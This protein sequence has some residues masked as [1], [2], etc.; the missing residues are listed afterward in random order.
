MVDILVVSLHSGK[1]YSED[2]TSFQVYFAQSCIDNGANLVVGHHPHVVQRVEEYS[3]S[4]DTS[5]EQS[6]NG[7]IDL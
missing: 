4:L 2:P 7:W 5:D 6:K 3:P 1:E